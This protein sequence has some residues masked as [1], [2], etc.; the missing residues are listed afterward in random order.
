MISKTI[1]GKT[2]SGACRYICKDQKRA[3]ILKSEGVRD[4]D[5]KLMA[6]DFETQYQLRPRFTEGSFSRHSKF[7]S[8]GE[9]S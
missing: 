4:Y 9:S 6:K 1:T 5:Y 3:V 2:F 8:G 7:L